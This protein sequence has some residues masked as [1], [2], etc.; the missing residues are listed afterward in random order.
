MVHFMRVNF[1][2][3][4]SQGMAFISGGMGRGMRVCGKAIKCMVSIHFFYNNK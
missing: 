1:S 2:K 3:E 4:R